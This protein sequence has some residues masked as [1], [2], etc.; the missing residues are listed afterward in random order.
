MLRRGAML[1]VAAVL[2]LVLSSCF[3]LQSFGVVAGTLTEGSKTTARFTLRPNSEAPDTSYQFIVVGVDDP[4]QLGI[5]KATWG[6]TG[7]FGG[8]VPM[9]ARSGLPAALTADACGASGL[10]FDQITGMTWKGFTTATVVNDKGKVGRAAVV[11]VVLSAKTTGTT[12]RQTV[13]GVTGVWLDDG[14]GVVESNGDDVYRCTGIATSSVY[15]E[16]A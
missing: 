8:P 2:P 9:V 7:T 13:I 15:I 12:R 10:S 5:G 3:V 1:L 16:P 11:D 6:A 14:D 4:A